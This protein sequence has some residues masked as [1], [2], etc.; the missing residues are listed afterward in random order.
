LIAAP[1]SR[2]EAD[3]KHTALPQTPFQDIKIVPLTTNELPETLFQ[4]LAA[5]HHPPLIL[6]DARQLRLNQTMRFL[7][8]TDSICILRPPVPSKPKSASS[9][10]KGL[11]K[12]RSHVLCSQCLNFHRGVNALKEALDSGVFGDITQIT[13]HRTLSLPYALNLDPPHD[14][15]YALMEKYRLDCEL[16]AWLLAGH[17]LR[18]SDSSDHC[19]LC[20][21]NTIRWRLV[22]HDQR[23]IEAEALAQ[24]HHADDHYL[25]L[26]LTCT[27]GALT[28]EGPLFPTPCAPQGRITRHHNLYGSK[29]HSVAIG[30][31]FLT[32]LVAAT[33]Q[34]VRLLNNCMKQLPDCDSLTLASSL[35]NVSTPLR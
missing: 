17:N 30:D 20:A 28:Y 7:K 1:A 19:R 3:F 34:S 11:R 14:S 10:R 13:I 2:C 31:P 15:P 5:Y 29:H 12:L 25:K 18:L 21:P 4:A 32:E 6:L 16:L 33:T 8:E 23:I 27:Q 26:S 24:P 9:L 22:N 35:H